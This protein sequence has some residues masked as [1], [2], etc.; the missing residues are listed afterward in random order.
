LYADN[1]KI[2]FAVAGNSDFAS[3]QGEL[4][5]FSQWCIHSGMQL[6]L[7][8]SKSMSLTRSCFTRHF[9]F[10]L[11]GHRLDTDDSICDLRVVLDSKFNF[12][13]HIDSLIVKVSKM[14][15]CIRRIC[16]KF[17]VPYTLETLYD[18]FVRSHLD[19]ASL[20]WNPYYGVHLNRIEAIQKK[21]LKFA[22]RT[23][24]WSHNIELPPY[25][26]GCR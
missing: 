6:K 26:Q 1:L 21:F 22:L 17:R 9:Q 13:S 12:T 20:V 11:S 7:G 23:L 2:F 5:V 18:S 8:K 25:Y 14:L 19:Y 15:G 16:K 3:A 10:E 24:G 4:D